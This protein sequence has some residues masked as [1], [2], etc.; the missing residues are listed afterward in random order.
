VV[1]SSC[2]DEFI[3]ECIRIK[4]GMPTCVGCLSG[5]S[6]DAPKQTAPKTWNSY[7]GRTSWKRHM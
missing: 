6:M 2:D 3:L 4:D 7:K 5:S 1:C